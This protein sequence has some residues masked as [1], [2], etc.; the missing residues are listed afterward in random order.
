[1][2]ISGTDLN[3]YGNKEVD[4]YSDGTLLG[5]A[6]IA[7]QQYNYLIKA[8][9]LSVGSHIITVEVI[10]N[11]QT[12]EV[13]TVSVTINKLLSRTFIDNP[14]ANAVI[15]DSV[16]INGWALDSF[17]ISTVKIYVDGKYKSIATIGLARADV[18]AAYPSYI[19]GVNSGYSYTLDTSGLT[20]GSHSIIVQAVGNDGTYNNAA[21]AIKK[22]NNGKMQV[23]NNLVSF[24]GDY[25]GYSATPYTG[26]DTQ[27]KTIGYGHVITSG[28]TYTYLDQASALA[29]LKQD[30]QIHVASVNVFTTGVDISQQQ[31][32]ALVD[33]AYNCGDNALM[34]STLLRNIKSGASLDAIKSQFLA[35]VYFNGV[36]YT[37]LYRRRVDEWNMFAYGDYTRS[38]VAAPSSDYK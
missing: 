25:E 9:T 34:Q 23:T 31:F 28:E 11:N 20:I 22:G 35:W 7:S 19:N 36:K 15:S 24:T 32:D 18:N 38:F 4:V 6:T 13:K 27:N 10:G 26:V 30:L 37:G 3:Q 8:R 33:F 2:N 14:K 17:G 1:L 21:V 5:K 29:L 16:D 12:I